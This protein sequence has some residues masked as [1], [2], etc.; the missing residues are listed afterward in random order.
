MTEETIYQQ[1]LEKF[2]ESTGYEMNGEADLAVRLRAA[3]TQIMSLYHYADYVYRQAF[4]QTATGEGLDRHGEL[5]GVSRKAAAKASGSLTFRMLSAQT[6]DRTVP[7]GTVCLTGQLVQFVT[8]E[9]GTIPAG[10]TTVT[11]AAE[12]VESGTAGNVLAGTIVRM[13]TLPAGVQEVT[14]QEA[15]SGGRD[16]EEDEAYRTRILDVYRG[17]SNGVNEA[18]FK[19]LALSVDGV[20]RVVVVPKINGIG[21][22][23]IIVDSDTGTVSDATLERV[24]MVV[25]DYKEVCLELRVYRP[26]SLST[27][28]QVKIVPISGCALEEAVSAV[29]GAIRDYVFSLNAGQTLYRSGLIHCA[30]ETGLIQ[31]IEVVTPETDTV[32]EYL[33]RICLESLTVE[34]A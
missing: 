9:E 25:G 10:E 29:E 33:Q 24:R 3:A 1:M 5:R 18:F 22:V 7:E 19:Q 30:M 6:V 14:N 34:G 11:V 2:Q 23:G 15:F 13:Q 28:V 17:V 12:A 27:A 31:D 32:A 26:E 20:D 8:T 4:P 16:Q 21:S